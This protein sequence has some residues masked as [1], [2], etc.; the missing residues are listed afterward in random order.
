MEMLYKD[1]RLPK[2]M[3]IWRNA[4]EEFVAVSGNKVAQI[5]GKN[6]AAARTKEQAV[7]NFLN[8]TITCGVVI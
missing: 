5:E 2:G 6:I 8:K 7:L 3:G 1:K 4:F